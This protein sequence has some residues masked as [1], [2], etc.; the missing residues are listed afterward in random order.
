MR[1]TNFPDLLGYSQRM[2]STGLLKARLETVSQE[3]VTGIKAD[4]T[5]AADGRVGDIHL[6]QKALAD[7]DV[8]TRINSLASSRIDFIMQG[9]QGSRTELNNIDVRATVALNTG[10]D[11]AVRAVSTEAA[12][13]LQSIMEAL[14]IKHGTR[15][16]FSGDATNTP[17]FASSDELLDDIKQILTTSATSADAEAA[18][19]T[20]FNDALGGFNTDI[21]QGGSGNAA[22]I[23][24]GNNETI[25]MD[26]RGDNQA[27]KDTLRGLSV[28][29]A[30]TDVGMD[31]S[32]DM[33]KD[34]YTS[35]VTAASNGNTGLITLEA[36]MGNYAATINTMEDR[37]STEKNTLTAAYQAI[38]GRDQFEAASELKQLEVA[39]ESSYIITARISDLS[40]TN[41]LR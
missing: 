23:R 3:A 20:Y 15:N 9:I 35:A 27:I 2:R 1:Y 7:I 29:A 10:N 5:K 24:L 8:E 25:N 22:S 39:L 26:I 41:Y 12:T 38:A 32:S 28:L 34:I 18:L 31:L 40:L 16:L 17:P 4:L 36:S 21:Y 13:S 11:D 19:D 30:S 33:F 6:L 14:S 37:N